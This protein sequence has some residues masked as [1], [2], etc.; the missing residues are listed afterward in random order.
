MSQ[1][2]VAIS[3][4]AQLPAVD[5]L[6]SGSEPV[7]AVPEAARGWP[8][9][10]FGSDARDAVLAA[11]SKK[12]L[13]L[14]LWRAAPAGVDESLAG[15]LTVLANE[16]RNALD[17]H[18]R[19]FKN[20]GAIVVLESTTDAVLAALSKAKIAAGAVES[21][22][23]QGAPWSEAQ[24]I[25]R[26][27]EKLEYVDGA[28]VP[29][30]LECLRGAREIPRRDWP[31]DCKDLGSS[32]LHALGP[33]IEQWNPV[34]AERALRLLAQES[35]VS[36]VWLNGDDG[37]PSLGLDRVGMF[38]SMLER[39]S[40]SA[41]R[42]RLVALASV[43]PSSASAAAL[44]TE[45]ALLDAAY[46]ESPALAFE[47][48]Y[49]ATRGA[50][51]MDGSATWKRHVGALLAAHHPS[52]GA[53]A[54]YA[55]CEGF[56]KKIDRAHIEHAARTDTTR[57]ER[58][59]W[60][61]AKLEEGAKKHEGLV[62]FA[63]ETWA[64]H[65]DPA[66]Y[67]GQIATILRDEKRPLVLDAVWASLVARL[68]ASPRAPLTSGE[69]T[70][71]VC[72]YAIAKLRAPPKPIAAR[73]AQ[74]L[75]ANPKSLAPVHHK[76]LAKKA[77][78]APK[79]KPSPWSDED[80][81]GLTEAQQ[82]GIATARKRS[83]EA[84]LELPKGATEAALEAAEKELG[85]AL[86]ADVRAFYALHDGGGPDERFNSQRLYSLKDALAQRTLLKKYEAGGAHAFDDGWLP[87]TDDGAGNHHCVVVKGKNAGAIMDFDHETGA[88]SKIAA[89][90]ANLLQRAR[91]G[92]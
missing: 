40:F 53:E 41:A 21:L 3:T 77:G 24:A 2:D 26:V 39:A 60:A 89:S 70:D 34:V 85:A 86:P 45:R 31:K 6:V 38:A 35:D 48:T 59:Q 81:E 71:D 18:G 47:L 4:A 75:A 54:L 37:P 11:L 72:L 7:L 30:V 55:L 79:A 57:A 69:K 27:K 16:A 32:V 61:A 78:T 84:G 82:K 52:L 29:T 73:L 87:L 92:E 51:L 80:L 91:W 88:G 83:W 90:F 43:E 5:K 12:F 68:E 42:S 15:E 23:E 28:F 44:I 58:I 67:S 19:I 22:R 17:N 65:V 20:D 10:V 25:A 62:T 33:A 46:K 66:G 76:A 50:S 64:K 8:I 63:L 49:H 36:S 74:W 9:L 56:A 1:I 14:E 13:L